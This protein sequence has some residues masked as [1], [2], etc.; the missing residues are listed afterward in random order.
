MR[1]VV[2]VKQVPDTTDVKINPETNTLIR[3][4]VASIINPF[5]ENALECALSIKD[6]YPDTV[7]TV[8]S[9]GPP[10]VD[11]MLRECIAMGADEAILLSDRNFAGADTLATSYALNKAIEKIGNAD[12][13]ICGKQAIDGDTAQVGP[14]V[15]EY[16]GINHVTYV[17]KIE[18][19]GGKTIKVQANIDGG[20]SSLEL[21]LPCL[22]T[23]L[24]TINQPRYPSL[25][26]KM[27]AKKK[28]IPVW[29]AEDVK[30]DF[31]RIGLKGSPT[32]VVKIF[33]PKPREGGEFI[34]GE[35]AE[36]KAKKLVG[37]LKEM[38]VV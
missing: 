7:V 37:F 26:G 19:E 30:A 8:L 29:K 36:D 16:L 6:K 34:D 22:L 17:Q 31:E 35:N 21:Q 28:E 4:G 25:K 9:M 24:K 5:D 10:Q 15:A 33:T 38:S 18:Y 12:L 32:V 20:Y 11:A 13:I 27:A 1:I 3:E 2:C 14:G 23:V